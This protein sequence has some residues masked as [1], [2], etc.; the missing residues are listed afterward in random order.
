MKIEQ[1]NTQSVPALLCNA[2]GVDA[3]ETKSLCCEAAGIIDPV[4]ATAEALIPHEKLREAASVDAA[5]IA[6]E[7]PP[8]QP[9]V[10]YK[11]LSQPD[12]RADYEKEFPVP[13]GL[14]YCT[15]R[16]KY[17]V[18][19]ELLELCFRNFN[20]GGDSLTG[21]EHARAYKELR[22]LLA[23]PAD[24]PVPSAAEETE[25]L[26]Y[27]AVRTKPLGNARLDRPLLTQVREGWDPAYSVTP[28][29]DQ[30]HVTRLKAEN[31]RLQRNRD[32]WKGQVER[33]AEKLTTLRAENEVLRKAAAQSQSDPVCEWLLVSH[34]DGTEW[35]VKYGS[36]EHDRALRA[37][38][39]STVPLEPKAE[40]PAL[41]AQALGE[42]AV[43]LELVVNRVTNGRHIRK[44][45]MIGDLS[46][47]THILYSAPTGN[48]TEPA[49]WMDVDGAL[50]TTLE[51]ASF[52]RRPVRELYFR[53]HAEQLVP[54]ADAL[55][56][57]AERYQWLRE[58]N[59]ETISCGGVFAGRTPHNVVLNGSDLDTAIDAA[60]S[61]QVTP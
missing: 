11:P 56:K 35:T 43:R 13:E 51:S 15:N 58:R 26:G 30:V 53:Q 55:R 40:P 60:M 52:S 12:E 2:C 48:Q 24:H 17:S 20:G 46:A 18:P 41:K 14:Q 10:G 42:P 50:H 9:V 38:H 1:E 27:R 6:Q 54:E 28:L 19:R 8:A 61:K 32:M 21:T 5:L 47:G 39:L 57:D 31:E 59:L 34:P 37:T 44:W 7:R 36:K 16:D 25:V 4:C 22:A 23:E 45:D 29:V 33:Q 3:Q 49:A